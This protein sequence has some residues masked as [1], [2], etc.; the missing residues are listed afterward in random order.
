LSD[1]PFR[2]LFRRCVLFW[3][4]LLFGAALAVA[5]TVLFIGDDEAPTAADST[6][7]P[8]TTAADST[9]APVTTTAAPPTSTLAASSTTSPATTTTVPSPT[10]PGLDPSLPPESAL[11]TLSVGFTEQDLTLRSGGPVDAGYLGG[12]C[13]GWASV[14]PNVQFDW[15]GDP[16]GLRFYFLPG[17]AASDTALVVR[18]PVGVWHCNNDSY[19][20]R[21]PTID[22][23]AAPEGRYDLWITSIDPGAAVVG[24]LFFT[25]PEGNHP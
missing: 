12:D 16:G 25:T 14:A 20:T 21:H 17:G 6:S 8:V 9:S 1:S 2:S 3:V 23:P 22:L 5:L 24:G 13:A 19:G 4:V 7:A 11:F 15:V 10:E 18:D